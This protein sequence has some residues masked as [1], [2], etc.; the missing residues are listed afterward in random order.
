M[1]KPRTP[2]PDPGPEMPPAQRAAMIADLDRRLRD[3]RRVLMQ[4]KWR[5]RQQERARGRPSIGVPLVWSSEPRVKPR[6]GRNN[7]LRYQK[8][9]ETED[10]LDQSGS[11]L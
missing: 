1:P 10:R 11:R 2:R 9:N 6:Y 5:I 4:N 8:T 3:L 7:P